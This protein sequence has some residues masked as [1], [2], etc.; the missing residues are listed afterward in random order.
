[1]PSEAHQTRIPARVVNLRDRPTHN[2]TC[3]GAERRFGIGR[4]V[5]ANLCRRTPD[6]AVRVPSVGHH[7]WS[8]VIDP[9]RLGQVLGDALDPVRLAQRFG[10]PVDTFA[11][12]DPPRRAMLAA[13]LPLPDRPRL[14]RRPSPLP[15]CVTEVGH[16][17]D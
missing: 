16:A 6:L 4:V 13:I 1:M 2:L 3:A 11:A 10:V 12:L 7:G 17:A 8:W 9:P 15:E 5:I 14:Q